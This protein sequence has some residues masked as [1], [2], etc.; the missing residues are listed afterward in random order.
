MACWLLPWAAR[1]SDFDS[2]AIIP[3]WNESADA[4]AIYSVNAVWEVPYTIPRPDVDLLDALNR[5]MVSHWIG[6]AGGGCAATANGFVSAVTFQ[7]G[8]SSYVCVPGLGCG[9]RGWLWPAG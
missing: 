6:I 3:V 9:G 5:P 1:A 2:C 8:T 7:A 4:P